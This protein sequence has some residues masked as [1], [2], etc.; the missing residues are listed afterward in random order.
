MTTRRR[1]AGD[2]PNCLDP[3]CS[4]TIQGRPLL[5]FGLRS[6]RLNGGACGRRELIELEG[7]FASGH[8]PE[9][10]FQYRSSGLAFRDHTREVRQRHR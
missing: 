7:G 8:P 9:P 1:E 3:C 4:L 10:L 2:F 6:T 5:H